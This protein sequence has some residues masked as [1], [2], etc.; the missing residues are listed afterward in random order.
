MQ[1]G[2]HLG[3]QNLH[4]IPDMDFFRKETQIGDRGRGDGLRL[5]RRSVEHHFTDYAA[6]PDPIQALT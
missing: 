6:C 2:V 5:R 3:F 4:G 1:I